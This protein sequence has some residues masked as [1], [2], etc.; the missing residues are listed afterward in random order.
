MSQTVVTVDVGGTGAN[1]ANAALTNLGALPT[2][3][4]SITGNLNVSNNIVVTGNANLNNFVISGNSIVTTENNGDVVLTPNGDGKLRVRS[5]VLFG[6]GAEAHFASAGID[7]STIAIGS[8]ADSNSA[9]EVLAVNKNSGTLAYSEFIAINDAGDQDSGWISIGVNSSNYDDPEYTLTG[10]DDGYLLFEPPQG[11]AANGDL[12]IGTGSYGLN[13]KIILAAGGFT[14]SDAQLI[15]APADLKR[16][17]LVSYSVSSNV[18]TFV[19]DI[20]HTFVAN[21]IV[22]ISEVGAPYDGTRTITAVTSNTLNVSVTTGDIGSVNLSPPGFALQFLPFNKGTVELT[23]QLFVGENSK[24]TIETANLTLSEGFA[25]PLGVVVNNDGPGQVSMFN[26]S[27]GALAYTEFIAQNDAADADMG[28]VSFGINS[29]GYDD[30]EF[31]ITKADDAYLLYEPPANT[32]GDGDLI[33]GTGTN[34]SKNRLIFAAEGFD[35]ANA[36]MIITPNESVRI[37]I[38][39]DASSSNTGALQVVGGVGVQGSMYVQGNQTIQGDLI[40]NGSQVIQ[41]INELTASGPISLLSDGNIANTWDQGLVGTYAVSKASVTED[42]A[43]K[44]IANNTATLTTSNNHSFL[45]EDYVVVA[46][47]D[48]TFDGTHRITAV[49]SNTFSYF[50]LANNLTQTAATGTGTVDKSAKYTGVVKRASDGAWRVFSNLGTRPDFN[51]DFADANLVYDSI[52]AGEGTFNGSLKLGTPN[53]ATITYTDANNR[54]L[55]IPAL[56]GDRT[57]AFLNEPQTFTAAQAFSS[58]VTGTKFIP[59]AGDA[60]GNG[61]YLAG[62]NKLALSADG[63]ERISISA[64]ETVINDGGNDYDFRVESD[65]NANMLLVDGGLNRVGI[66]TGAPEQT[67]HVQGNT[68]INGNVGIGTTSPT[69]HNGSNALVV[70]GGGGGRGIIEVWDGVAGKAVFQQLGGKTYIGNLDK[71][72]VGGT[73]GDLSFLVGGDGTNATEAIVIKSDGNVGIGTTSPQAKLHISD[74]S[75]QNIEITGNYIQSFNRGGSPGYQSLNF[76][77]SSYTFHVGNVGIGTTNPS[78]I[79]TISKTIDSAAYG[80]GTRAIDF[81]TYFPGFDVDGIKSSIYSGVSDKHTLNTFGGFIAFY[82][83]QSG[84]A[85]SSSGTNLIEA[86]RIEKDGKVGIGTTN[87]GAHLEVYQAAGGYTSIRMNTAFSGGNYVDLNPS[88]AGVSNDGFSISLNG[89]IRQIINASGNVGI[90]TTNPSYRLHTVGHTYSTQGYSSGA[91][92]TYTVPAGTYNVG[93]WYT[94]TARDTI[95]NLGLGDGMYIFRIFE[96]TYGAGGGNYFI[97]YLTEPFWFYNVQSNANNR[98]EFRISPIRMG[99]AANQPANYV[100]IAMLEEFGG[101]PHKFQWSPVGAN[102]TLD[103]TGGKN[104]V[105]YMYKFGGI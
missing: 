105:I 46:N 9:S 23:A 98:Q 49:S 83:N 4:G 13:N 55:S 94:F 31:P 64:S 38:A 16:A 68:Y 15:V 37:A 88:V 24:S 90:N 95:A 74:S 96:D 56:T 104:V 76:Y 35:E 28:W 1:N 84:F 69:P 11:T 47:V 21:D 97:N 66:G 30:P 5:D 10:P 70:R 60:T 59:T 82:V 81:K 52:I 20:T 40:V 18:V 92:L 72:S 25:V 27:N 54:T 6:N 19:T 79:L 75:T 63:V 102:L 100:N 80:S 3:G 53:T 33:I 99:H 73:N 26:K 77:G 67:L 34:G 65:G 2:F 61:L 71:G 44:E 85:G 51:T 22:S 12:I 103:G 29:S 101:V 62:T 8:V 32:T 14:P 93:T 7:E 57:F 58:T 39:T 36:Q 89:S 91:V 41:S 86:A 42:I 43:F 87:P 48:A 50:K 17:N 45:V 78:T